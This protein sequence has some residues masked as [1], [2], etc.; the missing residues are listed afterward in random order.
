[1]LLGR[2][3]LLAAL[4]CGVVC[5]PARAGFW[6]HTKIVDI[7]TQAP[8][9]G[10]F[11]GFSRDP[12]ISG[13]RIYFSGNASS[14]TGTTVGLWSYQNGIIQSEVVNGDPGP[15]GL[16]TFGGAFGQFSFDANDIAFTALLTGPNGGEGVFARVDG[17]LVKIADPFTPIPNG[18]GNFAPF[19]LLGHPLYPSLHDGE[20]AFL[21][22]GSNGQQGVYVRRDGILTRIADRST[23]IPGGS[24]TFT[25]FRAPVLDSQRVL[26]NGLGTGQSGI[27]SASGG[28]LSVVADLNTIAPGSNPPTLTFNSLDDTPQLDQGNAYFVGGSDRTALYSDE[29][30]LQRI[31]EATSALGVGQF[32]VKDGVLAFGSTTRVF[33][34]RDGVL[35]DAF[36]P[37]DT[38]EGVPVFDESTFPPTPNIFVNIGP[39]AVSGNSVVFHAVINSADY[40]NEAIYLATYVPE[41]STIALSLLASAFLLARVLVLRRC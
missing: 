10:N 32:A 33:H 22:N 21:G 16:G 30:G 13:G 31:I 12:A 36:G 20:V 26:F 40:Y 24:G 7:N 34:Y 17:T 18:I 3:F 37:H 27:Y 39:Q 5:S 25:G 14:N 9:I 1:L 23:A 4:F 15:D 35:S 38:L 19:D 29:G 11:G 28:A 2:C 6:Q 8:G 41:P